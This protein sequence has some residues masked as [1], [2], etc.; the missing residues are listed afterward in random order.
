MARD[1]RIR[2]GVSGGRTSLAAPARLAAIHL[3]CLQLQASVRADPSLAGQ[4]L[5]LSGEGRLHGRIAQACRRARALG[6]IEGMTI[7]QAR[8]T[9]PGLRV[10]DP[11]PGAA[12]RARHAVHEALLLVS[13]RVEWSGE[14][15]FCFDADG[16]SGLFGSERSILARACEVVQDAGFLCRA[17]M[18]SSRLVASVAARARP[19]AC[20]VP[21]GG[22]AAFLAPLPLSALALGEDAL[23]RLDLLGVRTLGQFARL[24]AD[25]VA[26]RFGREVARLQRLAR[27][28]DP[29][30]LLPLS[31]VRGIRVMRELD[32]AVGGI[33]PVTFLLKECSE[34]LADQLAGRGA[35]ASRLLLSFALDDPPGG[36]DERAL[37]PA[38]PMGSARA[39]LSLC[40]LEL[41]ERRLAAP[42]V[43][44]AIEVLA[45]APARHE[46]AEM[47]GE[48]SDPEALAA[49]LDRV[50]LL[51]GAE[52][53]ATPAPRDAH[54][55]EARV[56]WRPHRLRDRQGRR[57][58]RDA[59][60]DGQQA[61]AAIGTRDDDGERVLESPVPVTVRL[62][63]ADGAGTL[64][65]A[66]A[67]R[68]ALGLPARLVIARAE[69]PCRVTGEWWDG[70]ADADR[71]EWLLFDDAGG[72]YRACRDRR[73][74]AWALL[75]IAD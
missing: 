54:R 7:A 4:A 40:R 9:C 66:G 73:T 55:R 58:P 29:V 12:E 49:A 74:R 3:P 37:E 57:A 42:I 51:V 48:S 61:D 38:R 41:D 44:L 30:P 64:D 52:D 16:L 1:G 71:D 56:G 63:G 6:V 22:E 36:R 15:T 24:P 75:A 8:A 59:M 70:G 23:R 10:I 5:G 21:A 25:G 67:A 45:E 14:G 17:A 35:L 69:G 62:P 27:G 60:P 65:V 43:A 50:R 47:F 26:D 68:A 39:I 20:L 2:R 19:G 32:A 13:P 53:V 33:E 31:P 28:E 72:A 11:D 46:T 18:A 34:D